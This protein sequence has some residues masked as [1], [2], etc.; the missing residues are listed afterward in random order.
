[1]N[2]KIF[3]GDMYCIIIKMRL[4]YVLLFKKLIDIIFSKLVNFIFFLLLRVLRYCLIMM[5][6]ENLGNNIY[7]LIFYFNS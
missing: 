4:F 3:K 1:M 5:L 2:C 6:D 7:I